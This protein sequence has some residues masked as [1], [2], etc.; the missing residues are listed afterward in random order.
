MMTRKLMVRNVDI[1]AT[2]D[3]VKQLFS[4]HGDVERVVLNR[5]RGIGLIEMASVSEAIRARDR[6][7]GESLWGRSLDILSVENS[8]RNRFITMLHRFF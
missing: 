3:Q 8:F 2:E 6:L 7:Q 5:Q 4:I 1:D